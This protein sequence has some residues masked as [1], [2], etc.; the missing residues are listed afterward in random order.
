MESIPYGEH[1]SVVLVQTVTVGA[2]VDLGTGVKQENVVCLMIGRGV[3]DQSQRTYVA[4]EFRV[5]PKLKEFQRRQLVVSNLEQE[6]KLCVDQELGG[7][8]H[9][10][11]R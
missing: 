6:N 7:R 10:G 11:S 2:V 8:H 5:N 1:S 4:D 9:Q 3:K